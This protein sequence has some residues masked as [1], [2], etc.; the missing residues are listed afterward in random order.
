[1]SDYPEIIADIIDTYPDD[2][3]LKKLEG[4]NLVFHDIHHGTAYYL[5][6]AKMKDITRLLDVLTP[7]GIV[8]VL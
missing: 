1:M 6:K 7:N 3:Q 8:I 5:K 2:D 4:K